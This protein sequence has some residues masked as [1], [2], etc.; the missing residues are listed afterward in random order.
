MATE[1]KPRRKPK[2]KHT[3]THITVWSMNGT[4]VPPPVLAK[5]ESAVQ[6]V[7]EDSRL[8]V[9]VVRV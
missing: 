8:L 5:I 4:P 2:P 1:N 7:V 9:Q 3:A 6:E